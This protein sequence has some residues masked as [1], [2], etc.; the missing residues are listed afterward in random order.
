MNKYY[1]LKEKVEDH[2]PVSYIVW[3]TEG[4]SL[5]CYSICGWTKDESTGTY[6]IPVDN[7]Y[8]ADV[9]A[10][11]DGCTHWWFRGEDYAEGVTKPDSYYHICG[12]ECLRHMMACMAFIWEVAAREHAK[13]RKDCYDDF[14][15][16]NNIKDFILADYE[17]VE[18]E[19]K[20]MPI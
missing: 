14:E 17:I 8:V 9:Y 15:K 20:E 6:T 4:N 16:L 13:W 10:R 19:L 12:P 11:F 5:K 18:E 2:Q 3:D 7:H 1:V